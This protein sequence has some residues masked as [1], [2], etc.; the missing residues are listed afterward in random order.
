MFVLSG[1]RVLSGDGVVCDGSLLVRNGRIEGILPDSAAAP[2]GARVLDVGGALILPG[3]IDLH[4]DA[5]E[6]QLMPRPDVHMPMAVALMETDRQMLANGITTAYHGLTWSWE[7]GLRGREAARTFIAELARLR[8]HLGCDT[9]LHL[10]HEIANLA[11]E[12]ELTAL[13]ASGQVDL[14]AF[15]DH[16]DSIRR[17]LDKPG[18]AGAYAARTGLSVPAL[19]AL[20]D[21]LLEQRSEWIPSQARLAAVAAEHGVAM[22]S[23]DDPSPA[24]RQEMQAIGCTISEFPIDAE[25]ARTARDMG[26]PVVL[27]APN[28]LRGGS[29]C[30]RLNAAEAIGAGLGTVLTSD[31][32]YPALLLAAFRLA[33]DGVCYLPDAWGLVSW[34]AADAAGLTDRGRIAPGLR[35]DLTV[36]DDSLPECPRVQATFVNGHCL[37]NALGLRAQSVNGKAAVA[38][39]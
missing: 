19:Y 31:Y 1:G 22:A 11:D 37:F 34:N 9:R 3:I 26:S 16:I 20:I 38:A 2:D 12:P 24:F 33:Q 10:R 32:Y 7:P 27:G 35:A 29:H 21:S 17:S 6:R 13:L 4:G 23:H 28:I 25:T 15:N 30:G 8:P 18:K 36:V 14:L 5:F 39:T